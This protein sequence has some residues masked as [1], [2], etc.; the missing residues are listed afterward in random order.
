MNRLIEFTPRGI[1]CARANCYIDPK[2]TVDCAVIT[3][4]HSDHARRGSKHYLAHSLTVPVLHHRLG[5]KI[6]TQSVEYGDEIVMNGVRFSLHPAG[7]VIGSA[8]VRVEYRGEIWVV[9]GDYKLDHDPL[10]GSYEPIRCTV[11]CSESTFGLPVYRWPD[12]R[13]VIKQI[14]RWWRDNAAAGRPSVLFGYSLGKAQRLLYSI[15]GGIG[16]VF[17]HSSIR[18]IN[19]IFRDKGLPVPEAR[20]YSPATPINELR[21]A[22]III[23]PSAYRNGEAENLLA[24]ATAYASG[25]MASAQQRVSRQ[26][27]TGFVISDH[28]DWDGLNDA[29]RMSGAERIFVTHGFTDIFTRWLR[30]RGLDAY[31]VNE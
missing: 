13:D 22:L 29:V 24:S 30:E 25:W 6:S 5:K 2:R 16:P 19:D 26:A 23:P 18:S 15:D 12:S 27:D 3:H 1:Y 9:T 20:L 8:Q 7:H 11:F 4:A 28:A 14:N 31:S 21:N 17:V 10:A